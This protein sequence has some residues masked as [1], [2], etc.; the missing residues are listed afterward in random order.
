VKSLYNRFMVIFGVA[1]DPHD[2]FKDIINKQKKRAFKF[3]FFFLIGDY[4]TYDKSVNPNQKEFVSLINHVADYSEVGLKSSFFAHDDFSILKK[5]K[6]KMEDILNT[7]L[8][9]ARQSFSKLNLPESY[10]NLITLDISEDY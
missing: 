3:L 4:S 5:E 8:K 6:L 2:T 9:A 1:H 10:R 7:T